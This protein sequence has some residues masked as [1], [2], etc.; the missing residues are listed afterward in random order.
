MKRLWPRWV[1]AASLL[2]TAAAGSLLVA[3][4][5]EAQTVGTGTLQFSGTSGDYITQGESYSYSTSNRDPLVVSSSAGN[6]VG[7]QINLSATVWWT[8]ELDA[9]GS[10]VLAPGT[11]SGATRYPFDTTGPG[12][13]LYGEGRGC[14]TVT[15][16]FTVIDAVFG[17]QGYV[18]KFDATFVQHCEGGTAAASGSVHISNP[19]PPPAPAPSKQAAASGPPAANTSAPSAA[20]GTGNG[21]GTGKATGSGKAVGT[22]TG[23]AAGNAAVGN[24][25]VGNSAVG[26]STPAARRIAISVPLLIAVGIVTWVVLVAVAL[27]IGLGVPVSRRY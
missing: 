3:G 23:V 26:A 19:P 13:T 18:Q 8:L 14:N 27:G 2:F 15:G 20:S 24:T 16:S 17:P 22:D 6:E 12:L 10:A 11:Y 25:V 9:P 1:L 21:S 5:A 7:V 4:R